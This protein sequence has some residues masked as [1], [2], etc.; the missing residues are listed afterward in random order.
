M[1]PLHQLA[2]DWATRS[3]GRDHVTNLPIRSLRLAEEATELAQAYG[4]PREKMLDLVNIV[5]DRPRGD[6][7]QEIG[8]VMM[9]VVVLCAA[10]G[11]DP[12]DAFITELR[13][14]LEKPA[15]HFAQRNLDKVQLGLTA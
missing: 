5:Y 8:G 4:V 10:N 12:D 13:R 7:V 15:A 1:K 6:P 3:F 2:L 14:V 9:T 11:I